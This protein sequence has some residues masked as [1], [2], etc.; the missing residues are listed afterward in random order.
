[1]SFYPRTCKTFLPVLLSSNTRETGAQNDQ[2]RLHRDRKRSLLSEDL[3]MPNYTVTHVDY[4][5]HCREISHHG[6]DLIGALYSLANEKA[7]G[8]NRYRESL[9]ISDND[10]YERG[11]FT[12]EWIDQLPLFEQDRA[13]DAYRRAYP[14][15]V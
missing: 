1:M 3:R 15:H 14:V 7:K 11:W 6:D 2:K 5:G 4:N 12:D 10:D 13:W 8:Y 9:D